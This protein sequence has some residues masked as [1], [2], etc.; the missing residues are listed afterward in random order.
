MGQA[1]SA[2][3]KIL[4]EQKLLKAMPDES[5]FTGKDDGPIRILANLGLLFAPERDIVCQ[6]AHK[7]DIPFVDLASDSAQQSMVVDETLSK[8][9]KKLLWKHRALPLRCTNVGLDVAVVNP[10]DYELIRSLHFQLSRPVRMYLA[11][12]LPLIKRLSQLFKCDDPIKDEVMRAVREHVSA[13]SIPRAET[14]LEDAG[15]DSADAAPIIRLCNKIISDAAMRNA[16][17]I[18]LEPFEHALDVRFRIDG[19][20]VPMYEVPREAMLNLINRIKLQAKI[21]IS[22]RRRPQDGRTTMHISG[23]NIDLRVSTVPTAYGEKVVMRLL[24]Q[25]TRSLS[26]EAIQL[27]AP[28][29]A[30][31]ERT[32]KGAGKLLIVTGPT[33]S[34]KT[35]TLYTCLETLK[36]GSSNIVTVEDPIEYRLNGVNQ[37]QVNHQ[38]DVS[39][40]SVL[41][42]ILR[43]D[44]DVIMLGEMRDSETALTA[45]QAAQTGHLVLSTLHTNDAPSAV[46]RLVSLT[47]DPSLVSTS[48]SAVLAQRLV[49]RVCPECAI[50]PSEESL[51]PYRHWI[52]AHSIDVSKLRMG[53]GCAACFQLG[54]RGRVGIYSLFEISEE[55][56]ALIHEKAA[57]AKI[58]SSARNAGYRDLSESSLELVAQGVTSFPEIEPYLKDPPIRVA[59]SNSKDSASSGTGCRKNKILLVEDD[60]NIRTVL[61]M[62]LRQ[63]M[64][65]VVEAS[66]GREA[67]ERIYADRPDLILCD[68]MMP[69]M[70]GRQLLMRLRGDS[71]LSNIPVMILTAVD[72][73]NNEIDLLQLGALDFV[74]KVTS[75]NVLLTRVRRVLQ[76]QA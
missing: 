42:A 5:L 75:S 70:D 34:G 3:L 51:K 20:M 19:V 31:V 67:L 76:A 12:E 56:A 46:A 13:T 25:Q 26:F 38:I 59:A 50:A 69:V 9:D 64:I 11:E 18:H 57:L 60:E 55:I 4:S 7:L 44:P 8:L 68:L 58:E 45:L 43:Q 29:R 65:E 6:I 1:V 52:E 66:N 10:F 48:L 41:R 2:L 37:I 14:R 49:R 47:S 40:A 32:L 17:D 16:S 36:D 35:T 27:P 62:M 28:M 72:T 21:D 54:F 22:E 15:F 53:Q 39:F 61:S 63:D 73:E 24:R 74:S 23:E 33:G 71:Q 30:K